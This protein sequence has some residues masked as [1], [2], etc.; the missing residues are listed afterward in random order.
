MDKREIRHK[1]I[2][3]FSYSHSNE[4]T[5]GHIGD[6]ALTHILHTWGKNTDT[7]C[8]GFADFSQQCKREHRFSSCMSHNGRAE[9]Q[10]GRLQSS[11]SVFQRCCESK[12]ALRPRQCSLSEIARMEHSPIINLTAC[13]DHLKQ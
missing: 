4:R 1:R 10:S 11:W 9:A 5:H 2:F 7:N 12:D 3:Y 13:K 8:L 6:S